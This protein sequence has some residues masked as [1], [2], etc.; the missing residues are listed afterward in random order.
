MEIRSD[1]LSG[2]TRVAIVRAMTTSG[3]PIPQDEREQQ[4]RYA[5][6]QVPEV[7]EGWRLERLTAPSRLFGANGLRTGPD[8][9]IYIAH[10][11]PRQLVGRPAVDRELDPTLG[12]RPDDLPTH[13]A[14]A[15]NGDSQH[16]PAHRVIV[17]EGWGRNPVARR[18]RT[19]RN[20]HAVGHR[21]TGLRYPGILAVAMMPGAR[22][23]GPVAS[24]R[25]NS[26]IAVAEADTLALP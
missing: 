11:D 22:R 21:R 26:G 25:H 17:A 9:R 3:T 7:A 6:A 12:Q 19:E 23:P 16:L 24:Q 10:R 8:G 5:A 14:R 2:L 20:P 15:E 13:R 18:A 1:L 4:S